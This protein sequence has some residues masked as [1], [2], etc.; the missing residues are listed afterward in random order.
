MNSLGWVLVITSVFLLVLAGLIERRRS[1][2]G[3]Y[4]SRDWKKVA[5]QQGYFRKKN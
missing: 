1:S 4:L 3:V 5:Q 2:K